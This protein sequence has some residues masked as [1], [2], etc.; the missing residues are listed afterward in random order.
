MTANTVKA[1]KIHTSTVNDSKIHMVKISGIGAGT[2]NTDIVKTDIVNRNKVK[3]NKVKR[4]E[5]HRDTSKYVLAIKT[6]GPV[7]SLR[8]VMKIKTHTDPESRASD[9]DRLRGATKFRS[10]LVESVFTLD[11]LNIKSSNDI[12]DQAVIVIPIIEP[13]IN[14]S[15]TCRRY[16]FQRSVDKLS[17]FCDCPT[18]P[19]YT[20]IIDD[21]YI[22]IP[23]DVMKS[24]GVRSWNPSILLLDLMRANDDLSSLIFRFIVEIKWTVTGIQVNLV[25]HTRPGYPTSVGAAHNTIDATLRSIWISHSTPT[26]P[27]LISYYFGP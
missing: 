21:T 6:N 26:H 2:V 19:K 3:R 18:K 1:G 23:M 13:T 10:I 20:E 15:G 9:T 22:K 11:Y 14:K 7:S 16:R 17:K 25:A 8:D 12:I 27:M 5:S 4:R 24:I